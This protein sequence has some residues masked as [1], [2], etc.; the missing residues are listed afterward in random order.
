MT[1]HN[2]WRMKSA[3]ALDPSGEIHLRLEGGLNLDVASRTC[4][5]RFAV[6]D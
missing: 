1:D 4:A 2:P 5:D 3:K 6:A